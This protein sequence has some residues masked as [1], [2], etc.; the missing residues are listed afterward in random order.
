MRK[1]I[2]SKKGVT[3][4]VPLFFYS[5]SVFCSSQNLVEKTVKFCGLKNKLFQAYLSKEI[6]VNFLIK[7]ENLNSII[8]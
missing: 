7:I 8:D 1:S 5:N 3:N 6:L 4:D 2:F